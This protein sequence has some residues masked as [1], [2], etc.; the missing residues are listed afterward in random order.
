MDNEQAKR[1]EP[2]A[3]EQHLEHDERSVEAPP[4]KVFGA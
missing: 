4:Y 2:S 1:E 3:K